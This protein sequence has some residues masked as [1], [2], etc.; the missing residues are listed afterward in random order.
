MSVVVRS[1]SR[2]NTH[3]GA[4]IRP[5]PT[6]STACSRMASGNQQQTPVTV[7]PPTI[8]KST[9]TG[10]E[11]RNSMPLLSTIRLTQIVRGIVVERTSCASLLKACVKS[12]TAALN[13]IHGSSAV[14][15]N[16]MYGSSPT[17]RWKTWVKTNQ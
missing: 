8:A 13:H 4:T 7:A 12:E 6:S 10:S 9:S 5:R 11:Q 14:S 1:R 2:K 15:R 16:T 3:S 17:V